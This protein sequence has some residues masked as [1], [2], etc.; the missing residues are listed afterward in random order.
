MSEPI[1]IKFE[2]GSKKWDKFIWRISPS[3]ETYIPSLADFC[4]RWRCDPDKL[5]DRRFSFLKDNYLVAYGFVMT[6]YG[7]LFDVSFPENEKN[8]SGCLLED[9]LNRGPRRVEDTSSK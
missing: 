4:R 7:A 1:N 6:F 3:L 5:L 2:E 9:H 8:F